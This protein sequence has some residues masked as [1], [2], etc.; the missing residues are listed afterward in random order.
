[1]KTDG[2][3]NRKR[4][5]RQ[6]GKYGPKY[7]WKEMKDHGLFR[8]KLTAVSSIVNQNMVGMANNA[9]ARRF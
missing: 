5:K 7:Q 8:G 3:L 2:N 1:L 6:N 9:G 4:G